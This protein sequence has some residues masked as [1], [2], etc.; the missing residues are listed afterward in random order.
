MQND[1]VFI[2]FLLLFAI[3]FVII[4]YVGLYKINNT[5]KK[6]SKQV[7]DNGNWVNFFDEYK[8]MMSSVIQ[9]PLQYADNLIGRNAIYKYIDYK[10][11]VN[12]RQIDCYSLKIKFTMKTYKDGRREIYADTESHYGKAEF[13]NGEVH[14]N[15]DIGGR[16]FVADVNDFN[17]MWKDIL[18]YHFS[19]KLDGVTDKIK[20]V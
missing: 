4:Y 12:G 2:Y 9:R 3:A 17:Q 6:N 1:K 19:V 20:I 14:Q 8:E 10:S 11:S 13:Y 15:Y 16:R 5:S 18:E 7:S